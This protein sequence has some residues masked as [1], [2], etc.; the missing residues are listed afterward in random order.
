MDP[1]VAAV[2]IGEPADD[3]RGNRA[4]PGLQGGAV[5]DEAAGLAGDRGVDLGRLGLGEGERLRLR[6]D[7][8]VDL[9]DVDRVAVLGRQAQG[10]REVGRG[11]DHEQ[12]GGIGARAAELLDRAAGVQREAAPARLVGRAGDRRHH[13]RRLLLEQRLEAA[14]VRRGEADVGAGVA[15]RALDRAEEAGEVVDVRMLEGLRP[16]EQQ[17][18]VDPQLR[19]I[20]A[21]AERRHER[22]RLAGAERDPERVRRL[23]P[24]GCLLWGDRV[25]HRRARSARNL[26]DRRC[27][28]RVCLAARPSLP[29]AAASTARPATAAPASSAAT[30]SSGPSARSR[31]AR[32]APG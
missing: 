22:R 10:A 11:L 14:E 3:R 20:V 5:G 8:D 15:Q 23:E 6:G 24:G 17:G 12:A 7:Q 9:I 2:A 30:S 29:P 26:S 16:G 27:R 28:T 32:S 31:R 4:D 18:A 19:P 1:V 21:L 13:P 25:R